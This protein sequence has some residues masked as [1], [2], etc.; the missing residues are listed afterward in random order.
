[1]DALASVPTRGE[2]S[3][4][5]TKIEKV[6]IKRAPKAPAPAASGAAPAASKAP[7]KAPVTTPKTP[8]TPE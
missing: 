4:T 3:I 7:P 8:K 5:P 1:M 2:R 6:T